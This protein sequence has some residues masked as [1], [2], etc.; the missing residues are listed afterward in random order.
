VK[1]S[2]TPQIEPRPSWL[3][4]IGRFLSTGGFS[5]LE[6]DSD[7]IE[8]RPEFFTP[9]G[10]IVVTLQADGSW[11]DDWDG[12]VHPGFKAGQSALRGAVT[13]LGNDG[14]RLCALTDVTP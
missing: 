3:R 6:R 12:E 1:S 9:I 10:Y 4:S 14:A 13:A 11:K 5:L 7:S 2:D 8:A